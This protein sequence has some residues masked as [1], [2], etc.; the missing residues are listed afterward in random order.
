M[1]LQ[2]VSGGPLLLEC[3]RQTL[4]EF[5]SPRSRLLRRLAGER[6]LRFRFN[7]RGLCTAPH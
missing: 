4:F 2:D 7:L 3:F 1:T 5:V 6:S